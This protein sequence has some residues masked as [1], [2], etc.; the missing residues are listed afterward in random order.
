MM[1]HFWING[2]LFS[3]EVRR[4][5]G[6]EYPPATVHM[7]LC[8]LQRIMRRESE[9]PFEILAKGD[10]RFRNFHGTMESV[11]QQLHKKGVGAVVKHVC[12]Y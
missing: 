3:I 7:L 6:S 2:F 10:V 12:Y 4:K 8:G 11:F 5:D 1:Q 9:H